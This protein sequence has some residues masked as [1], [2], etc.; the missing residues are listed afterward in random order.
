MKATQKSETIMTM[1]VSYHKP[2][3]TSL[4]YQYE[5]PDVPPPDQVAD[6]EKF[7]QALLK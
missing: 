2:E 7:L 1:G 4:D 3:E 5:M 6:Y